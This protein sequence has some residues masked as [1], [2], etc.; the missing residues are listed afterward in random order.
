MF[1]RK[2]TA[3]PSGLIFHTPQCQGNQRHNDQRVENDRAE[4]RA[5]RRVQEHDV[6]FI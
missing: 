2:I 1:L 3:A 4:N 5:L 6:Q